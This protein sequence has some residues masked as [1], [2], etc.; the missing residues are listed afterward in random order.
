[1]EIF[2]KSDVG[3]LRDNNEDAYYISKADDN[4][5]LFVLADG[6]GGYNGGEVASKIAIASA[7][8]FIESNY[9]K[10]DLNRE[11]IL[12]LIRDAIEYA[13]LIVLEQS[14]ENV[15]LE[16]M[17]TTIEICIVQNN[18]LFIGHVGDSRIYRIRGEI[19]RKLTHDHSYVEKLVEDGKI[20][21]EQA[22][23]HPKKNML[24][25]ALGG[26][27]FVEPDLTVKGFVTDDII[28]IC[29]DGLTNMLSDNQIYSIVTKD[30]KN[31]AKKLIEEA[32]NHGGIDNITVVLLKK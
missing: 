13:N 11:N 5:K 25:K 27:S 19:I 10:I 14:K 3:K 17:G 15:N 20:T 18:K 9:K 32:N 26:T 6:M 21:E 31:A 30:Y 23:K 4:L 8:R 7:V 1:M 16:G 24:T 29:S 12:K 28:L 2:A 22:Q